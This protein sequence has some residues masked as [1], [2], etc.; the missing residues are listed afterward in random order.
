MAKQREKL[1]QDQYDA[2]A[3]V[4]SQQADQ[5]AHYNILKREVDTDREMYDSMLQ[6]VKESSVAA[7]LK[8]SN[9]NVVDPAV[10]AAAATPA[11]AKAARKA[12]P[13]PR[14]AGADHRSDAEALGGA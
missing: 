10:A 12:T 9:I 14:R 5:V 8:A 7:A 4:V 2:A 13:Q 1:L 6:R 11:P 3:L